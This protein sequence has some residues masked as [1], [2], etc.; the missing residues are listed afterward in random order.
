MAGEKIECLKKGK[1]HVDRCWRN[2]LKKE[3]L[4]EI[5]AELL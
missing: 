1:A 4:G 5:R 3:R 2:R